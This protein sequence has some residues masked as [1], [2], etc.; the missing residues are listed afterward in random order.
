MRNNKKASSMQTAV[1][2][3]SAVLY[4]LYV[5][6]LLDA[7]LKMKYGTFLFA[8]TNSIDLPLFL[9]IYIICSA[10]V[11]FSTRYYEKNREKAKKLALALLSVGIVFIGIVFFK[12]GQVWVIRDD[13]ISYNTIFSS[14][15]EE[16]TYSD[17][18][19]VILYVKSYLTAGIGTGASSYVYDIKFKDGN[20]V[21]VVLGESTYYDFTDVVKFDKKVQHVRKTKGDF[22]ECAPDTDVDVDMYYKSIWDKCRID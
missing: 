10:V 20:S 14:C 5:T 22:S 16:Y 13:M 11:I 6:V 21:E 3:C 1:L 9:E 4:I 8:Y 19:N 18:E 2:V 15:K 17:I 12:V 7:Y